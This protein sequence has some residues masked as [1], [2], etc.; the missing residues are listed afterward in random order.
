MFYRF[1]IP[2]SSHQQCVRFQILHLLVST[3]LSFLILA[4][5]L[6]VKGCF[7]VCLKYSFT[8][9]LSCTES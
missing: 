1:L 4:I 3:C 5:F 6:C 2:F 9:L 7:T 8:Y